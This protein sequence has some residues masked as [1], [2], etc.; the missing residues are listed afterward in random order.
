[1]AQ[2]VNKGLKKP[3]DISRTPTTCSQSRLVVPRFIKLSHNKFQ[4]S[5]RCTRV[6]EGFHD[7]STSC[8]RVERLE[9]EFFEL[10]VCTNLPRVLWGVFEGFARLVEEPHKLCGS[11]ECFKCKSYGSFEFLVCQTRSMSHSHVQLLL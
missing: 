3:W 6:L 1:M 5:T 10:T 8:A 11:S 2:R 9:E 4:G 7:D